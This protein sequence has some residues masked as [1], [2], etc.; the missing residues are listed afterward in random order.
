MSGCDALSSFLPLCRDSQGAALSHD[1]Q[2]SLSAHGSA[3]MPHTSG[4]LS[5]NRVCLTLVRNQMQRD[6]W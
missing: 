2:R 4:D 1:N 6:D 3:R 5:P